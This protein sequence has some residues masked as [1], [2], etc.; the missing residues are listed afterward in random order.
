MSA[1][2][3]VC[4]GNWKCWAGPGFPWPFVTVS[5]FAR[6]RTGWGRHEEIAIR[7]AFTVRCGDCGRRRICRATFDHDS[8]AKTPYR[9]GTTHVIF[10][11]LDFLSRL[12][13]LVPAPGVNLTRFHGAFAP[14][15][16]LRG[17]IV[18][19]TFVFVLTPG[20]ASCRA[21]VAGSVDV[22]S[23]G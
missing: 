4:A 16:R 10:E 5:Q 21:V 8:C 11:P 12:A 22:R 1:K 2:R 18:S 20:A 7:N 15:H 13:A 19:T 17:R 3:N 6:A 14:N 23:V 9:D